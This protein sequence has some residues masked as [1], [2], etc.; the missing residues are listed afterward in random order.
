LFEVTWPGQKVEATFDVVPVITQVLQ[1]ENEEYRLL[2]VEELARIPGRAASVALARRA[3]YDTSATIRRAASASLQQRPAAE[4]RGILLNGFRYAWAPVAD[5][6][7]EALIETNDVSAV[8]GLVDMLDQGDPSRPYVE[9]KTHKHEVRELVRI[10]H[11]RNCCLCH[12]PSYSPSDWVR[13]RVMEP[14]VAIPLE[15][16]GTPNGTFVRADITYLRPEFS[17]MLRV[18]DAKPWPDLQRFDFIVRTRPATAEEVARSEQQPVSTNYPQR[19]ALL[20]ALRRLSGRDLDA[21]TETW[22]K[23]ANELLARK[24]NGRR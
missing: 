6:A 7:A 22:R 8:P 11:L 5:H 4:Y 18:E 10:N 20:Y 19:V 1:V 23:Y 9:E 14:G 24:D 16:Y 15:Y 21:S 17:A 13:G 12:A 3:L 2:L